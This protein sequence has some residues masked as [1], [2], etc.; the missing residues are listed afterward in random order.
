MLLRRLPFVFAVVFS[1]LL[2]AG[3][4]AA[5]GV[6]S[7]SQAYVNEDRLHIFID[8]A[9]DASSVKVS[10]REAEIT[11]GGSLAEYGAV[12]R[13]T[14]LVDISTSIPV[15][16]RADII[17]LL[18]YF[19]ENK[20]P[21]EE[22][23]IVTFGEGLTV[24]QD[25]TADRYDINAAVNKISYTDELTHIYDS[26]Y[27][28]MPELTP[29]DGIPCYYR[30]IVITDGADVADTGV[31][32]SELYLR[33]Q[34]E[35]YPINIIEA[36]TD[37]G[38]DK[39][40]AALARI[41]GGKVIPISPGADMAAISAQLTTENIR[42]INA[43][44]PAELLDGSVRQV[45]IT[46]GGAELQFDIKIPIY[47]APVVQTPVPTQE[48]TPEPTP[49]PTPDPTA[50]PTP[51]PTQEPAK[52][53]SLFGWPIYVIA[54]VSLALVITAIVLFIMNNKK[55]RP[56]AASPPPA[57]N[58]ITL[59]DYNNAAQVW[60]LSLKY[61]ILIGRNESCQVVL[62]DTSISRPQCRIYVAEVP[63]LEHLGKANTTCLNGSP[64]LLPVEISQG[65]LIKMGRV[66]LVV[67]RLNF[68]RST[69]RSESETMPFP[70]GS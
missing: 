18:G 55:K 36:V 20:N 63:M 14:F 66:T 69:D 48:P 39:D 56:A 12:V 34:L 44:I 2:P 7:L 41:S 13:T 9:V 16:V 49:V 31:T 58:S 28:M 65:D 4:C 45:N 27:N 26:L 32:S 21:L 62:I 3:V 53:E 1:L 38:P 22:Y 30:C 57:D 6:A 42:Y 24:L 17:T 23:R 52:T 8:G 11:A 70:Y 37:S 46:G 59:C 33:L 5:T 10:N 29:L 64:V 68:L 54:G 19:I 40:I 61:E 60:N 35:S 51:V 25:F 15:N 43:V 50:I 67:E 47:E